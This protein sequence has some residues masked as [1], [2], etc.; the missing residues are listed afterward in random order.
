MIGS[1]QPAPLKTAIRALL[2]GVNQSRQPGTARLPITL[3]VICSLLVLSACANSRLVLR[4]IYNGLDDRIADR[5]L[6]TGEFTAE[7]SQRINDIVDTFHVWHRQE[8]LPRYAQAMRDIVATAAIRNKTTEE[9]IRRWS[10]QLQD[11]VDSARACSPTRFGMPVLLSLSNDQII[12]IEQRVN[13]EE[14]EEDAEREQLSLEQR[15]AN[16]QKRALRTLS[17]AGLELDRTQKRDLRETLLQSK[18]N[19]ADYGE[20]F[21]TWREQFFSL[22]KD[23]DNPDRE[24]LLS[25]HLEGRSAGLRALD[26]QG[27]NAN[28]ELWQDYALRTLRSLSPEQREFVVNWV[29]TLIRTI[30][31]LS[32][33]TPSYAVDNNANNGCRTNDSS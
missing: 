13:E 8:E 19:R 16:S 6:E 21:D 23:T 12:D 2:H 1:L 18:R 22:L 3:V 29:K 11:F 9:D 15:A 10:D 17:F 25:A 28:R 7:Q 32:R 4:P 33:D 27:R 26:P 14:L 30:D 24:Q 20:Y 31:S 5:I